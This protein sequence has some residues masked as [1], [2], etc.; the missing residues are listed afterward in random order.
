MLRSGSLFASA[1]FL[2]SRTHYIMR[3]L[4][5]RTHFLHRRELGGFLELLRMQVDMCLCET[6]SNDWLHGLLPLIKEHHKVYN[7]RESDH[8]A[9][10]SKYL[11]LKRGAKKPAA[12]KAYSELMAAKSLSDQSRFDMAR[13]LSQVVE[14]WDGFLRRG[15]H[16]C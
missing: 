2:Q 10:L 12:E 5:L 3:R 14:R 8:S 15:L 6:L 1:N 9:A 13:K 16:H 11:A 7:Q 4:N